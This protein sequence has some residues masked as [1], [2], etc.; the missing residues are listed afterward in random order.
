MLTASNS[1]QTAITRLAEADV[2]LSIDDFGMG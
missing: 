1:A 2:Q